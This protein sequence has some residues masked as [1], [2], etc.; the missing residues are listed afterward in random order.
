M[1]KLISHLCGELQIG[2]WGDGAF[3]KDNP[4]TCGH[5]SDKPQQKQPE[6]RSVSIPA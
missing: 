4:R 6:N 3:F 2:V 5:T 1:A